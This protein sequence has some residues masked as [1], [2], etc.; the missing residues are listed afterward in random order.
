MA[1]NQPATNVYSKEQFDAAV[2]SAVKS[3]MDALKDKDASSEPG[4]T[5][6]AN[7]S[8]EKNRSTQL[9]VNV[10]GTQTKARPGGLTRKEREQLAAD[11]RLIPRDDDDLP[12][13][14]SEEP[15]Q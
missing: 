2:E 14:F 4:S 13:V 15:N 7:K 8:T 11:L 3:R 1:N 9:A 5:P 6:T 10:N 12:F